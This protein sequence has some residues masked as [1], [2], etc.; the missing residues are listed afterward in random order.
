MITLN[1]RRHHRGMTG[2]SGLD[3]FAWSDGAFWS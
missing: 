2:R 1:S 3:S